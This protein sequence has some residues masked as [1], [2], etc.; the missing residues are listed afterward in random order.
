MDAEDVVLTI[1]IMLAA[2]L[3]V[4]PIADWL[5]LPRMLL[6]LGAGALLG[7]SVL[8]WIDVPLDAIGSQ[9]LL[10][11][12]VSI[13]LF[14][15]GLQLSVRVLSRV[16]VGLACSSSRRDRHGRSGGARRVGGL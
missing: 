1:G 13:I 12:G 7:P 3:V 4:Q 14:Y 16:V 11:L 9:V 5:R 2:G 6:L 15:G 10:T 8:D